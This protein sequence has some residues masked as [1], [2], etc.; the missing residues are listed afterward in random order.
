M[1]GDLT[2]QDS[3]FGLLFILRISVC[4]L[5]TFT[6]EYE[7]AMESIRKQDQAVPFGNDI[8]DAFRP[9]GHEVTFRRNPDA[10]AANQY[11]L[12][13]L[14]EIEKVGSQK[15]ARHTRAAMVALRKGIPPKAGKD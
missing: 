2:S 14:E 11:L 6:G 10:E 9:I 12:W 3:R 15:A 1:T 5:C 8:S 7:W 4:L 13:A